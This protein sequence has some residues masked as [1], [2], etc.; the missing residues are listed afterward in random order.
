MVCFISASWPGGLI[1]FNPDK[2]TFKIY[3]HRANDS[4]TVSNDIAQNFLESKSGIIWFCTLGGGVNAF[5]PVTEKFRAFTTKDGLCSNDVVSITAD[6]NGNYW[7]G[8]QNGLSCFTPPNNPFN[9]KDSFHFRN[10]DKGD[11]L[12]DN[13]MSMFAG[14]KDADGKMFFGCQDAGL[15]S[16]YPD[17]L[18][19][20][21]YI[22]PVY[23]TD[24]KLFNK[25]V[26]PKDADSI[27]RSPIELTKEIT[28]SY[29]QNAISFEFAALNFFH[30]ERNQYAYMLEGYDK[31][32]IYTD[33]S[34]R[35]ANYTN[36]DPGEYIFKVKGSNND[37]VWNPVVASIKLIITPPYWQTWWFRTLLFLAVAA[38]VYGLYR[39]RLQHIL[40]LQNIR[41]KIAADLHDDIGSTLNSISVYSE[42]AKKDPARQ[43]HALNMIG[44]SSRKV[45]DA[46]SDIVWT[47]NP[48]NDSFE[49]II[50]RMRSLCYNLLRAKKIDFTFR[51]DEN[52]NGLKL[53]LEE[54]RNFY[55]IFKEAL[56][57][58]VKYSAASRV[59]VSLESQ[60]KYH[61][62]VNT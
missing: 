60:F 53:S 4:S 55:L 3:P 48:D 50:L 44:E 61:Y 6:D 8:T 19:D 31:D 57:N 26:Q 29:D 58:L 41:N 21:A 28:L 36:L 11:G 7:L 14:Y 25:S 24:F 42:V 54:R 13:K 52:L 2:E 15:I 1:T 39:F 47:I 5:D 20:N 33:A 51:A 46:M 45:I 10:Y 32:W 37:G 56:N 30:P 34:K 49:K 22:P 12:P 9:P 38:A 59:S 43:P 18:K 35:F 40:K 17:E 23:I 16:L 27:L 62:A